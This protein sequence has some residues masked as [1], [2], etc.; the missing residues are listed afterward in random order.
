[1]FFLSLLIQRIDILVTKK[2]NKKI[3]TDYPIVAQIIYQSKT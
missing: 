1:M 3:K 2:L